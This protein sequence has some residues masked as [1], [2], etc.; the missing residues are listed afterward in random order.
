MP[1][2]LKEGLKERLCVD[3]LCQATYNFMKYSK[4]NKVFRLSIPIKVLLTTGL[5]YCA[6]FLSTFW[7][8]FHFHINPDGLW[9]GIAIHTLFLFFHVLFASLVATI[10]THFFLDRPLVKLTQAMSK[11]GEG[12]F[13]IRSSLKGGDEIGLLAQNFNRMLEKL[14]D[15]SARKIQTDHDLIIV[16]EELKYKKSLEDKNIL[17]EKTNRTLE[18]L[19]KDLS[20]LY[21]IG[22]EINQTIDLDQL[23]QVMSKV[24]QHHLRL[25]NFSLMAWDAKSQLLQVKAAFGFEQKFPILQMTFAIGEGIAGEVLKTG[26]EIYVGDTQDT[27]LFADKG[28]QFRGSMLSVPLTYKG[29]NLGVI[30]FGRARTYAFGAND[31]KMLTLVANQVALAMANAR[32]YTQTRELSVTDELTGVFNRRHFS[33][34][35][36]LEWK[37]AVRFKRDLSLLMIDV[38]FFK[39]YNDTYGHL[40]GDDVLR[41]M[42]DL[43]MTNL[44][45]VDT[46]ARFGG[47]EF[48]VL[49]PDTDK[50]G[51]TAVAEKLRHMVQEK[52]EN[53]TISVGVGNFPDDVQEMEDLIDH[54]DIALYSAKDTGRNRVL[55]YRG[56]EK[57]ATPM[58]PS[59]EPKLD[60]PSTKPRLVH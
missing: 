40:K 19:V 48:I 42:G 16:Q 26:K 24:L 18:N 34:V 14:T 12:D 3:T 29:E 39:R 60:P 50:R 31:I 1:I 9:H 38:D 45:E 51:A 7:F 23:Y 6:A 30:N 37:R 59:Q 2:T 15:L 41:Q 43:L 36:Q 57:S 11:A 10:S 56:S 13:L 28:V 33:Q 35:L 49:L 47:E 20:V 46:V 21:E 32:L 44:R 53:I 25:E 58:Q 4:L 55:T 5:G 17:I 22:Q 27:I 52:I 8:T 54:A